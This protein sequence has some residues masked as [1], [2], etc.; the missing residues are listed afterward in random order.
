MAQP[1]ALNPVFETVYSTAQSITADDSASSLNTIQAGKDKVVVAGVTNDANDFIV[2]PSLASV[3]DGHTI[4][5]LNNA[6]SNFELRT[7]ATS[8]EKIN[9]VDSDG[10]QEYL[11]VDAEV[12]VLTKVSGTDGW[13][14]YDIP[15]LGGV[16]TA[17]VPD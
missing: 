6:G 1:N 8:G 17:T 10:T 3:P 13:S 16:G 2:L 5:V 15:A 12:V 7:P 4:K 14:A 9:T 11:C